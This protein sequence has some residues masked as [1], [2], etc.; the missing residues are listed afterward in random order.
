MSMASYLL[1]H[2]HDP[3]KCGVAFAAF[4]GDQSPHRRTTINASCAAAGHDVWWIVEAEAGDAALAM[5][6]HYL[7]QLCDVVPVRKIRLP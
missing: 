3:E 7:A 4:K 6:P 1:H 2:R 5:L